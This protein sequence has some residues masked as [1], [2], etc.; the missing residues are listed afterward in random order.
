VGH[1]E[2]GIG[3]FRQQ[4]ARFVRNPIFRGIRLNAGAIT[5]GVARPEF[6]DD[7]KRLA[8]EG[9]MLDAIGSA[10][11]LRALITLTEKIPSL[12]IAIDHMPSEPPGWV[13][14]RAELRELAKSPRVYAKAAG[15]A[16]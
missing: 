16:G 7:L 13:E 12:R 8:G 1:L 2:P 14:R 5:A 4:L 3:A 6:V 11:M 10:T 9:L 15:V